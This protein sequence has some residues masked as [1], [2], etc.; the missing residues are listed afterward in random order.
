MELNCELTHRLAE[1]TGRR[2]A[3]YAARLRYRG[4]RRR[5]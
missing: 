4:S 5:L 3:P 2:S 1:T